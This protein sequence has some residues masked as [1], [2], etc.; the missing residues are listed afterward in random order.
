MEA[1]RTPLKN[2]ATDFIRGIY[3]IT[4]TE[5]L[6][7]IKK[8]L[9]NC[10]KEIGL[11]DKKESSYANY[12][13]EKE[14]LCV[15]NEIIYLLTRLPDDAGNISEFLLESY[16]LEN[17]PYMR[18]DFAYGAVLKGPYS[19]ALDYA[20]RLYPGS[21]DDF[22]HRSWTI[23]YFND[24][25]IDP[26]V[27]QDKY[28]TPWDRVRNGRL[29]RLSSKKRKDIRFRILDLPILYCFYVSRNWEDV[30]END[31]EK[32]KGAS[33]NDSDYSEEELLFLKEQKEKLVLEY[34]EALKNKLKN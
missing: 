25:H 34:E 6:I 23:A 31:L 28:K 20:K 30:N 26:Y 27:Y 19:I 3:S 4:S 7:I 11:R 22:I 1:L 32:I 9:I 15:K 18:L 13:N 12:Y 14:I 10:Y 5:K 17:N 8:N 16:N 2:D 24:V 33:I 29:G 21:E